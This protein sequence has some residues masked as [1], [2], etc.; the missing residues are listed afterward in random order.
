MS[1]QCYK[2]EPADLGTKTKQDPPSIVN[3]ANGL[4]YPHYHMLMFFFGSGPGSKQFLCFDLDFFGVRAHTIGIVVAK[5]SMPCQSK[6]QSIVQLWMFLL[7]GGECK[8]SG[9]CRWCHFR[10]AT[11]ATFA[12]VISS[13]VQHSKHLSEKKG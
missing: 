11:L 2:S 5:P 6:L 4:V 13:A 7:R 8:C 1:A 3:S 12:I 10:H 9:S